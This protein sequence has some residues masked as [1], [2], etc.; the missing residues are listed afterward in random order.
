MPVYLFWGEDD[1]RRQR[2]VEQLRSQ[3]LDPAWADFNFQRYSGEQIIDALNEAV[4]PPFGSGGR[5]VWVDEPKIF[6]Q[7]SEGQLAELTRTLPHIEERNHL[8]FS[9][10]SKPDGRLK[11]TKLLTRL[12]QV[13][14]FALIPPWQEAKLKAQIQQIASERKI[15]LTASAL[16][17]LAEAVGN[18]TC[19]LDSELEKLALFAQGCKV[20]VDAVAA[21]VPTTAQSSFQ[22]AGA[23]LAAQSSQAL[24]LI[25][26]LLQ[27]NEPALRI[28]A[29]LVGQFRTWL[30]VCLAVEAGERDAQAIAAA[31]EIANP[32]RVYFLQKEVERT[33]AARLG[34]VLPVLLN[35]EVHLKT[36]RPEQPALE[37]AALE[38][39][40]LLR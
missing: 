19:R 24:Q 27:R 18:D 35:L 8:L 26:D 13:R 29:V 34:R 12:A 31:A 37:V 1:Y 15:D 28:L 38:I 33:S 4:T 40:S 5:L 7:C 17:L 22:L 30:L 6:S 21:L 23:L 36:G 3:V 32:A 25:A 16:Q 10:T 20:E 9:Q 14:E 39:A 2:A 11:S